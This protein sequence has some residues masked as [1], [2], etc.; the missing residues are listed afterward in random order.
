MAHLVHT[1]ETETEGVR[2]AVACAAP[3][4]TA[5]S[6]AI[7][8]YLACYTPLPSGLSAGAQ[9][10]IRPYLASYTQ[11]PSVRF[12]GTYAPIQRATC[13]YQLYRRLWHQHCCTV[14]L[15][16]VECQD[17]PLRPEIK[18]TKRHSL[19]KLYC[20]RR[21]SPAVNG[22]KNAVCGGGAALYG[23]S[24][25]KRLGAGAGVWADARRVSRRGARDP[26]QIAAR[27]AG[28]PYKPPLVRPT[29]PA[30]AMSVTNTLCGAIILH[31]C[32]ALSGSDI[33]YVPTLRCVW[34]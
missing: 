9:R 34:Y 21:G 24:V 7:C 20:T 33:G 27:S 19:Y 23:G 2:G 28:S 32:Y 4:L 29:L 10:A 5:P 6:S 26:G 30:Y 8:R 11:V 16:G 31:L 3:Y 14:L 12:A 17:L 25:D 18:D 15:H 13:R 1:N 22:D